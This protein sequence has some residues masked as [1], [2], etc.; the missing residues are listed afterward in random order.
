L[1]ILTHK[2]DTLIILTTFLKKCEK[3]KRGL[4]IGTEGVYIKWF[5][6][7]GV[8]NNWPSGTNSL[9]V[10]KKRTWVRYSL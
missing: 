5:Q 3:S 7:I 4:Y 1:V 2:I 10:N 6:E 9:N 8:I